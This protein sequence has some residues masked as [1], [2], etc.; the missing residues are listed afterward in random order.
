MNKTILYLGNNI[1]KHGFNKTTIETLGPLL[2]SEGYRIYYSSDKKNQVVRLLDMIWS[3]MFF[4]PRV[5][6]IIIDTYSTF[7]FYYALVSSQIARIF[8]IKYVPILHGGNLP[9]RLEKNPFLSG[10][11]FENALINVAPSNY[12][13]YEFERKGY[14]NV[15]FIPNVLNVDCYSFKKRNQ[16]HPNLLWVRAFDEIYNPHMAIEV[17][18]KLKVIYPHSKLCMI[19]P[20]KDGSMHTTRKLAE[21]FGI[22]V[23]ITGRLSRTEWLEK[24]VD[25]D[26]FINTTNFDNTP[27]SVMEALALG[28]PVV[29]TNVGGISYLLE[30]GMDSVLVQK[31]DVK[32]MLRGILKLIENK[33]FTSRLTTN[34]RK[35][36]EGFDWASVKEQWMS[37][38]S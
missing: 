38:L 32:G 15:M 8:N 28:I 33:K 6:Y 23:E 19:G 5:D 34:G 30:N 11:L 37:I 36:A 4:A 25:Y 21:S 29:S 20:D 10:L 31:N 12:L 7:S 1:S 17:F 22:Q 35:K 18:K 16:I 24:S 3:I 26:I 13:K 9:V 2:E 14:G 27:V